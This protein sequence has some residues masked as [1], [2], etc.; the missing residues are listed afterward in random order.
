[1]QRQFD[2]DM[3][4]PDLRPWWTPP[5]REEI[6]KT[7]I[8]WECDFGRLLAPVDAAQWFDAVVTAGWVFDY[9]GDT[10]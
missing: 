6:L 8:D 4:L 2:A 3:S 5:S 9:N 10:W 7:V 1:M